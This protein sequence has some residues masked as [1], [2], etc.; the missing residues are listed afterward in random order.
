MIYQTTSIKYQ[1]SS[2]KREEGVTLL[3]SIL[4]LSAIMAIAFSLATILLVEVRVSGDLLRTEPAIYAANAV[5][6]EAL[7]TVKRGYPRCTGNCP[8]QFSYTNRLGAVDVNNPAPKE[9]PFNNPILIDKVLSTSNSIANTLNRYAFYDPND[10]NQPGGFAE[11]KVTYKNTGVQGQIHVYVCEF[12][13]PINFLPIDPP[14]DCDTPTSADMLYQDSTPLNQGQ[15]TAIITLDKNKQQELIIYSSGPI[16]DRFVQIE[17]FGPGSVPKGIP[18]FGETVVDIHAQYGG[19][20]RALRVKI[21][22]SESG[23]AIAPNVSSVNFDGIDDYIS[24]PHMASYNLTAQFTIEAWVKLN[25]VPGGGSFA[26]IVGKGPLGDPPSGNHNY[27]FGINNGT[28]VAGLNLLG[29]VESSSGANTHNWTNFAYPANTW[30]HVAMVFDGVADTITLYQNG[31]QFGSVLTGVTVVPSTNTEIISI[32]RLTSNAVGSQINGQIDEVRLWNTARTA[33]EINANY[34][35]QLTGSEAGLVG[36]WNFNENSGATAG[37]SVSGA[38]NGTLLNGASWSGN[39][40]F[41]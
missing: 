36:Y 1:V 17:A 23:S 20:T 11:L 26:S 6:E 31:V 27:Y 10:I 28:F 16:A 41:P 30:Y 40:P 9:N 14:I 33:A 15:S 4:V 39:V 24:V 21:P 29:G 7:F 13:A 18:F 8:N 12:K 35:K 2:I 38:T 25:A 32:G 19:V 34:S 3:L 22:V 5:T 37:N